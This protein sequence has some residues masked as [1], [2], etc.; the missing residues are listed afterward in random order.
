MTDSLGN[1]WD[2][3]FENY[4]VGV[5]PSPDWL[6]SGNNEV[7]VDNSRSIS[8]S[9]SLKLIGVL[10]SCWGAVAHRKIG[11]AAPFSIQFYVYNGSETL[12]GCHPEYG[13]VLL[14]TGPDWSTWV[15]YLICF[16][17][18]KIIYGAGRGVQHGPEK[19]IPIGFYTPETW[20][21]VKITYE[22]VSSAVRL[23]YWINDEYKGSYDSALMPNE[24]DV[25]YVSIQAGEGSAWFDEISVTTPQV[26]AKFRLSSPLKNYNPYNAPISA[27]F[28][29]SSD[30]PYGTK[31]GLVI[32]YTGEIGDSQNAGSGCDCYNSINNQIF[33]INGNYTGA[34]SCGSKYYLCYDEHPGFDY[35]VQNKTPIYAA[36]KGIAHIPNSF[37]GVTNAQTFNTIEID[38]QNGYKTYY[39]HLSSQNVSEGQTI[40]D[41]NNPIG[42][43]GDVGSPGAYHLHFEVQKEGIPVDPYGWQSQ[44]SDP[45]QRDKNINLWKSEINQGIINLILIE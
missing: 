31:D 6:N 19:G 38:H 43:S 21:K 45:Y 7:Y 25:A 44:D 30:G 14:H 11:I 2:E 13:A 10:G 24:N 9:K 8:G 39:L 23:T 34:R 15:R 42:Y 36:A 32:A 33:R 16:D 40:D 4:D 18:D 17:S 5:F 37:P 26:E 22:I 3:N 29:H 20:Y 1:C 35:P 12:Y 28:D 41:L 27:V